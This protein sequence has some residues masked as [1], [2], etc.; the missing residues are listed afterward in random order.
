MAALDDEV[1]LPRWSGEGEFRAI[2]FST[3][4]WAADLVALDPGRGSVRTLLSL[5]DPDQPQRGSPVWRAA[6]Q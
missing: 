3:T 6:T 4:M 5:V 1:V 2:D